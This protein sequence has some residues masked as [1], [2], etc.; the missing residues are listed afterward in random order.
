[1]R[2]GWLAPGAM[3]VAVAATA[4][5][6][7]A[8]TG[9][10]SPSA[11]ASPAQT[12]TAPV[13]RVDHADDRDVDV[14]F[15]RVTPQPL[16]V[17][18]GGTVTRSWCRTGRPIAS[19]E[20]VLR[21]DERVVFALYL[22][23]PPYREIANGAKGRDVAALQRELRRLG[24]PI[25]VDGRFGPQTAAALRK[26][27]KAA[28][29]TPDGRLEPAEVVWLPSETAAPTSCELALGQRVSA[30]ATA[31]IL[32]ARLTRVRLAELP[33]AAIDGPRVA[34]L[35]GAE[36]P[37]VPGT[38]ITDEAFLSSIASTPEYAA[39]LSAEDAERAQATVSLAAPVPAYK[40]PPG[41]IFG[42]AGARACVQS[43]GTAIPVAIVG[44]G[45]GASLVTSAEDLT[46]VAIGDGITATSCDAT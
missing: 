3:L 41:A 2:V 32:P 42:L 14:T 38:P 4:F 44:S 26:V 1:M 22:R 9:G 24:H 35:F 37:Y 34:R 13:E 27:E 6:F 19:G 23:I 20:A 18:R 29:A 10:R 39:T 33:Q 40:I 12:T 7:T 11:L 8:L 43:D 30:G 21:I 36:T 17:A 25:S 28:G 31:A 46:Q 45:L 5:G 16:S 15:D